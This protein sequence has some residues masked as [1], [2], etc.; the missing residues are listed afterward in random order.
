MIICAHVSQKRAPA[1]VQRRPLGVG[2]DTPRLLHDQH[3]GG[4]VPNLQF[5]ISFSL[6]VYCKILYIHMYDID[7]VFFI[8]LFFGCISKQDKT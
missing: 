3:A 2:H 7:H 5:F 8:F 6:H 1:K 4:V